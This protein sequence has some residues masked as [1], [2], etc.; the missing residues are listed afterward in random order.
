MT[1][2]N[3]HFKQ[4]WM[5]WLKKIISYLF[6]HPQFINGLIN[7]CSVCLHSP[8]MTNDKLPLEPRTRAVL[9]ELCF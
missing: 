4:R 5:V 1:I 6:P 2:F 7:C 3:M 8:N 9:D